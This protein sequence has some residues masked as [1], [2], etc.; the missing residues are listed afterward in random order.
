MQSSPSPE[1]LNPKSGW[2][3]AAL[4]K[5]LTPE[6][7]DRIFFIG[8]GQTSKRAQQFCGNC[9]VKREC[10]N[11]A[12][13][14]NEYGIWAGSTEEDRRNLD[15]FIAKMLREQAAAEGRLESRNINDFIPLVQ[16]MVEVDVQVL[17]LVEEREEAQDPP[18]DLTNDLR[19]FV[20]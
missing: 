5:D 8:P 12:I 16:L 11:F 6:E 14:Y 15:P 4:C 9:P 1:D 3:G 2:R 13:T 17:M 20:A 19:E 7:S 18:F 10:N